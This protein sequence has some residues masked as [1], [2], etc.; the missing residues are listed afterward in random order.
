VDGLDESSVAGEG[1]VVGEGGG[2]VV[3]ADSQERVVLEHVEA[4]LGKELTA[5][6]GFGSKVGKEEEGGRDEE[7][8][9]EKFEVFGEDG[10][11]E[12]EAEKKNEDGGE[13]L[14]ERQGANYKYQITNYKC[15]FG[16]PLEK[17]EVGR[18]GGLGWLE[19]KGF[20]MDEVENEEG[21][22][23]EAGQDVGMGSGAIGEGP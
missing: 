16:V 6:K 2:E 13:G 15:S 5:S 22:G 19:A 10:G 20:V 12:N 9:K 14:G 4:V 21:D 18:G 11:D 1:A 23:E 7:T 17:V 3:G 8:G